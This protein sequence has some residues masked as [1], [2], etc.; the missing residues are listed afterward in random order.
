MAR[1]MPCAAPVTIATGALERAMV[2]AFGSIGRSSRD[3]HS[4]HEPS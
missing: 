2:Q 4:D 1:P 3:P